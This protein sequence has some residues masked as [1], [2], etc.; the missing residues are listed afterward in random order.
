MA[1]TCSQRRYRAGNS[2]LSASPRLASPRIPPRLG[3]ALLGR[4]VS[5]LDLTETDYLVRAERQ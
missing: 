5:L 2:R 4:G 3:S 1:L